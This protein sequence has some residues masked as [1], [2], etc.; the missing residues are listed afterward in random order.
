[1]EEALALQRWLPQGPLDWRRDGCRSRFSSSGRVSSIVLG[2]LLEERC[3][4]LHARDDPREAALLWGL[5]FWS[6]G[7]GT[8]SLARAMRRPSSRYGRSSAVRRSSQSQS[9]PPLLIAAHQG[10]VEEARDRSERALALAEADD[11][12]IAQSGHRWV[13]GFIELSLGDPGAALGYLKRGWEIRDSVRALD[14]GHRLEL[15]DTLE[16]LIAVGELEEAER[17]LVVWEKRARA[18]DRS[19]ALAITARCR[20]LLLAAQGDLDGRAR[21]AS[22]ARSPSMRGLRIRSSTRA[23]CSRKGSRSGERSSAARLA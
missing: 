7:R 14:P 5:A 22:S 1:M 21:R 3:E 19:W 23:P 10:R 2:D 12:R 9:C 20:A 15:A 18:L 6:C 8:G 11:I 17:K 16:A 13:L 4:A